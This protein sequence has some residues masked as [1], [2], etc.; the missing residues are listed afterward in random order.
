DLLEI[1][2]GILDYVRS[3]NFDG[4]LQRLTFP[5]RAFME[6]TCAAYRQAAVGKGL[7]FDLDVQDDETI[8]TDPDRLDRV[9]GI[10]LGNAIKFTDSG[11]VRVRASIER[12]EGNVPHLVVSVRDTGAGI[13]AQ[14][15]ELVFESF[16]KSTLPDQAP[17][18]GAGIGLALA[19]NIT[20]VLGG[21]L[22]MSSEAG[23]GSEFS[24]IVPAAAPVKASI[25][26]A[27]RYTVLIVDDNEV[28]LEYM[29][30]LV[31]NAG[32]RVHVATSA[33]E[34]F[35]VLETHYVDAGLLDIR[36]PG[37]SG[38]E[39]AKAIRAYAGPRYSPSMPLFAMTAQ[40]IDAEQESL[41][42]FERVFP[43]PTDIRQFSTALTNAMS[44]RE[45]LSAAAFRSAYP[46]PGIGL[47]GAIA[48]VQLDVD[49]ALTALSL[50]LSG[51][52]DTRVDIR[53]EAALL[54]SAFHRFSCSGGAEFVRLFVEH[55]ANEDRDVLVGLLDRI[56]GMLETGITAL[57]PLVDDEA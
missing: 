1:L 52:N 9:V 23:T 44:N 32:F 19:R 6:R 25:G 14:D 21:E 8:E 29:R 17:I 10:I 38:T 39:L 15:Q 57:R 27:G 51:T 45:N 34:A 41:K 53:A 11:S 48:R 43:K 42:L 12:R 37:F 22:R 49:A 2:T 54:S 13:P 33:A 46:P 40:D 36:M 56:K 7:E 28:N 26:E 3:E 50:A 47:S 18:R 4:S 16:A 5:L 55:Y 35:R 20:M 30:T 24:V 31:E